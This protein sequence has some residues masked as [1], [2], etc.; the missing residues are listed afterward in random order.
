MMSLD[1]Q[2]YLSKVEKRASRFSSKLMSN[3]K[4]L[5]LFRVLSDHKELIAKCYITGIWDDIPRALDIPGAGQFDDTF[6]AQGIKDVPPAGPCLFKEIRWIA[7]PAS[8]QIKRQMRD[9]TLAPIIYTQDVEKIHQLLSAV[10]Q[11][12]MEY[13]D[14][15][16]K[17][18]GYK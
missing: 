9:E 10:G 3:A 17:V 13:E 5:K 15:D 16:L 4:W 1:Y 12:D 11:L 6:Y 14:G 8:W 2:N 18:Y 7:F